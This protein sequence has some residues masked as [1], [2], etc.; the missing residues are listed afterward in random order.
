[1]EYLGQILG[2][3]AIAAV[4]A[5]GLDLILGESGMLA[6]CQ[7]AFMAFG[8]Y[9]FAI[10]SQSSGSVWLGCVGALLASSAAG[11]VAAFVTWRLGQVYFAI[12]TFALQLITGG[13]LRNLDSLTGGPVGVV[14]VPLLVEA[15]HFGLGRTFW[16]G[17]F[18]VVLGV[19]LTLLASLVRLSSFGRLQRGIRDDEGLMMALGKNVPQL[20]IQT[21]M[22]GA[23]FGGAAGVLYASHLGYIQP[24]AFD[25]MASIMIV[26]IVIV[27]GAG[28]HLGPWVGAVIVIGLPELLRFVG[29]TTVGIA[30]LREVVFGCVIVAAIVWRPRGLLGRVDVV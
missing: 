16:S 3:I 19:S 29:T 23:V 1:M 13:L 15:E 12:V 30:Q 24:K 27:G 4:A 28:S 5:L 22:A 7:A 17:I 18:L 26:A 10:L 11:A 25:M 14:G 21:V 20:R 8:A 2:L 9:T 6:L